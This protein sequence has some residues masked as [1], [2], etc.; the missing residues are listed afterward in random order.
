[1]IK[2]MDARLRE[3]KK[4]I[5]S[6]EVSR[7]RNEKSMIASSSLSALLAPVPL[8]TDG[9]SSQKL[10]EFRLKNNELKLL[11]KEERERYDSL[12]E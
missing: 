1:M 11:L 7:G 9:P 6:E 10:E 4:K 5:F 2:E 12:F 3:Q 8:L